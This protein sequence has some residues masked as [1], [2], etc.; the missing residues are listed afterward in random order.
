MDLGYRAL[1]DVAN[2]TERHQVHGFRIAG[3]YAVPLGRPS[4]LRLSLFAEPSVA[5]GHAWVP[6][7]AEIQAALQGGPMQMGV[8]LA[9]GYALSDVPAQPGVLLPTSGAYLA[10][11]LVVGFLLSERIQL[12]IRTGPVLSELS[13]GSE[14]SFR[15]SHVSAGL[16]LGYA[17]DLRCDPGWSDDCDEQQ[18]AFSRRR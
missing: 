10:P 1:I 9:G 18:V 6:F 5:E 17:F 16:W 7:G 11:T 14:Q 15:V 2:E 13:R 3:V 4:Q 8:A 12:G